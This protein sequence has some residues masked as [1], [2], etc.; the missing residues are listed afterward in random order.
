[1]V[2]R[3]CDALATQE[4]FF[5]DECRD[6]LAIPPHGMKMHWAGESSGC[7]MTYRS[8]AVTVEAFAITSGDQIKA[9]GWYRPS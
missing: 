9:R 3:G 5:C 7:H 2:G 8:P 6:F 4:D 1:M